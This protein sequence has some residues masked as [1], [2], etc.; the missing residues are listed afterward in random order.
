LSSCRILIA[1]DYSSWR[2]Q[3]R[4]LFQ[5]KPQWEVI[6][7]AEDGLEAV[8][9]AGELKP[10][11][12]VLDIGLPKL[13]GIEAARRI[14]QLAPNSKIVFL[15]QNNDLDVVR[16]ALDTGALGYVHKASARRELLQAVDAALEGKQFVDSSLKG[17]EP[18]GISCEKPRQYQEVQSR[19]MGNARNT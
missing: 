10:D 13:N 5:P 1:D 19:R 16:A 2:R 11:L 12:I 14:R 6:A 3:T 8:Q 7:E 15:T 17:Y 9:K 4:L 18:S